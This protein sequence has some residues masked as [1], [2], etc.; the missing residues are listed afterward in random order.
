MKTFK[1]PFGSVYIPEYSNIYYSK[2]VYDIVINW[3]IK[4]YQIS[5]T[6]SSEDIAGW[7]P[8]LHVPD[9]IEKE[10]KNLVNELAITNDLVEAFQAFAEKQHH[11]LSINN[12]LENIIK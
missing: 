12:L 3:L 9:A 6:Y 1:A 5:L 8:Q 2:D 4:I 7:G 10:Y 11:S